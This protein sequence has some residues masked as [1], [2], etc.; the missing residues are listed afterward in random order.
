[1]RR[2]TQ[3]T[4][5]AT[6]LKLGGELLEHP[7]RLAA[8]VHVIVRAASR[9]PLAI[10]HGGGREIDVALAQAGIAKQQVDGLRVTDAPT[11]A[12]VVAVLAG[13]INTRLVAALV[14]A[15]GRAVGLTGADD[16][17]GLADLM[18]PHRAA[19]GRVVPLGLVGQPSAAVSS[20]LVVD[21]IGGG[22]LPVMACI[23]MTRDG[24]LLNVNADTLAASLAARLRAARLVIAGATPGVL[25]ERGDTIPSLDGRTIAALVEKGTANAGM[26]AKLAACRSALEAGVDLVTIV[27]GRDASA[28]DAALLSNEDA[29]LAK[30]TKLPAR[31]RSSRG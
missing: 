24:A 12:V 31:V 8:I 6:I 28:L 27:D 16:G 17:V 11:L 10:V 20:R 23:G 3:L 14:A 21:L 5:P 4:G 9:V 7:D 18:A 29:G 30:A 13:T 26:V 1:M 22:Y 25:D 19:D 15:G 2:V